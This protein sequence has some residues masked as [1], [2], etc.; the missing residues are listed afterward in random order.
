MGL[1]PV[2][3]VVVSGAAFL[4]LVG[5]FLLLRRTDVES[6]DFKFLGLMRL[7]VRLRGASPVTKLPSGSRARRWRVRPSCGQREWL[8]T[9]AK[10]ARTPQLPFRLGKCRTRKGGV[11]VEQHESARS[12][13]AGL[14]RGNGESRLTD[15]PFPTTLSL[16]M[17]EQKWI[18]GNTRPAHWLHPGSDLSIQGRKKASECTNRVSGSGTCCPAR[19]LPGIPPIQ[20]HSRVDQ[21]I[22]DVPQASRS[23]LWGPRLARLR[24]KDY[25]AGIFF[26]AT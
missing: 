23:D 11:M 2:L 17:A 3:I 12:A 7:S 10:G 24:L 16:L 13:S 22:D 14:E 1:V 9:R 5:S 18:S 19:L 6:L 20:I 15:E 21:V 25:A 4:V 8:L 26:S